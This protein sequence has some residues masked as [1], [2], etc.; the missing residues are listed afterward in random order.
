[1]INRLINWKIVMLLDIQHYF[2][3]DPTLKLVSDFIE[4]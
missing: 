2:S 1:M 3:I 4:N